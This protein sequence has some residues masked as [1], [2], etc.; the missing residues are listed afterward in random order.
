MSSPV[1]GH[2]QGHPA[3]L[4]GVSRPA[5]WT[6]SEGGGDA[7]SDQVR[8][9]IWGCGDA[10]VHLAT[11]D[12]APGDAGGA[13]RDDARPTGG[14]LHWTQFTVSYCKQRKY[15][16]RELPGGIKGL[17]IN[18][19]ILL[20]VSLAP[21]SVCFLTKRVR[22]S[23]SLGKDE[24]KLIARNC[25]RCCQFNLLDILFLHFL[26]EALELQFVSIHSVL[27]V[28]EGTKDEM[29]DFGQT[30]YNQKDGDKPF[31][32]LNLEII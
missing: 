11:P 32:F 26:K 4:A 9:H 25:E 15:M 6:I 3:P 30:Q 17:K 27:S 5:N 31:D 12:A 2:S 13:P 23:Q 8:R 21:Q 28:F 24:R 7:R 1:P 19:S 18:R 10:T 14:Q 22:R 20:T 16:M 29:K